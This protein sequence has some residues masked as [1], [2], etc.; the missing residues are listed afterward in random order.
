MTILQILGNGLLFL[1][2][3]VMAGFIA[4]EMSRWMELRKIENPPKGLLNRTLRRSIGAFLLLVVL[5]LIKYP[6]EE[7]LTPA[8][9]FFKY[10][11]C[12][13]LCLVVFLIAYSDMRSIR[14]EIRHELR[15]DFKQTTQDLENM[16]NEM[17]LNNNEED[18]SASAPQTNSDDN[19]TEAKSHS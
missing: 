1:G 18:A 4:L 8:L 9:L 14:N 5:L 2:V 16:V 12:L 7:S 3:L 13:W 17:S 10:L 19:S 6:E 15:K 11:I